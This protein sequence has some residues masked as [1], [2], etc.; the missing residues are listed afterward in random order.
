MYITDII[1]WGYVAFV[2]L[3]ALFF[4]FFAHSVREKGE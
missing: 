1:W 2:A 4:L 3:L